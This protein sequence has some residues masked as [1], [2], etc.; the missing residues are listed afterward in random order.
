VLDTANVL[1]EYEPG[2]SFPSGHATFFSALATSFYFYHKYIA[3]IYIVGAFLIGASR[4]AAGIHWPLDILVGYA[5]G[6]VIGYLAYK[7]LAKK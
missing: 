6:G 1:F 2:D 5:L 7:L 3:I 4:I